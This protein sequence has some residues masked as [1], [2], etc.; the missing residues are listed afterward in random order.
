MINSLVILPPQGPRAALV[1]YPR[2]AWDLQSRRLQVSYIVPPDARLMPNLLSRSAEEE[3]PSPTNFPEQIKQIK[4]AKFR[5]ITSFAQQT[6]NVWESILYRL[7]LLYIT[8]TKLNHKPNWFCNKMLR[9]TTCPAHCVQVQA[10]GINAMYQ[11]QD[12]NAKHPR[13]AFVPP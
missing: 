10:A 9:I 11:L 5:R 13:R 1:G 2:L 6:V 7:N 3:R 8:I 12:T 4:I